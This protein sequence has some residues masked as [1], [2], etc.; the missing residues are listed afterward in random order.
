MDFDALKDTWRK[1]QN[2][3]E[4]KIKLREEVILR[5]NIEKSKNKFDQLLS[6]SI[7]GRNLALLYMAMSI[8]ASFKVINEFEYSIPAMIG[9]MAMLGSFIM[10][11]SLKRP[12][13]SI[14]NTLTLQKSIHQ[15][16]IHTIK[17]SKYDISIVSLWFLTIIPVYLKLFFKISIYSN[18][19]HFGIFSLVILLT[20][21]LVML[22]SNKLYQKWNSELHEIENQLSAIKEFELV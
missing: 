22:F 15:F 16:R 5:M 17:S 11:A 6:I 14:M 10:H 18:L 1:E 3:L 7:L 2:E 21:S 13:I 20:I 4:I 12:D 9:G 19:I 8:W